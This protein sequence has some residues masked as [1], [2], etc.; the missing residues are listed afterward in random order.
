GLLGRGLGGA[1]GGQSRNRHCDPSETHAR[2]TSHDDLHSM[3]RA[4]S[5][6]A[7][8]ANKKILEPL[9]TGPGTDCL[10]AYRQSQLTRIW[11]THQ[12]RIPPLLAAL[13]RASITTRASL[14]KCFIR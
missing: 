3:V 9:L 13:R 11:N 8:R 4:Q 2:V 14:R 6:E 7:V 5:T 1:T 12:R 10:A